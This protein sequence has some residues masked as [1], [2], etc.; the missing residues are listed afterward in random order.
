[1]KPNSHL[2]DRFK[3]K[4]HFLKACNLAVQHGHIKF[5]KQTQRN[6]HMAC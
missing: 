3:N 4:M 6:Q 5:T 1:M 2:G